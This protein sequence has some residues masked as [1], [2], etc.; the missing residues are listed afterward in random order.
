MGIFDFFS[1]GAI[2]Q[3]KFVQIVLAELRKLDAASQYHYNAERFQIARPDDGFINLGNIYQEYCQAEKIERD[4]VLRRFLRNCIS[5][6]N[7]E[8]PAEFGDIHPDLLPVIR[9]RF[10][11][12]SVLLQA[13]VRGNDAL[14]VPQQIVGEHLALS[15]VYD[16]PSAMR[17]ISLADLNNWEVSFDEAVEAARHNLE[18]MGEVAFATLDRCVY[19]SATGDNYDASRLVM[20]DLVRRFKVNGDYV[21]MVPNRDT[22]VITGSEDEHGL[23]ILAKLAEDSYEKPRPISTVAMRLEGEE[24]MPWLP[25]R[26]SPS[27]AK[28]HELRLRTIGAEYNDQKE[29]LDEVHS[30]SRADVSVA[31]FNAMQNKASGQ[32]TSYSVWSE[33]LDIMLP[34]TDSIFFFRPK[35]EKEGEIVAGGSWDHV[36][37]IVGNLM[38][39]AGIYPERYLVRDFPSDYQLDAI[40][41]QIEP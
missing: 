29:L 41:K 20:L 5:T 36:Q 40:G 15:L 22:L 7:Y 24:W 38:E 11:L 21:A 6:K 8:L 12:E 32:V 26:S 30:A 17:T 35:G 16:L 23:A 34:Q 39:P 1:G 37:Q 28:Y 2:T 19:A 10:Y 9:S 33:G 3:E 4:A 13:K 27:F 31:Q 18:Q 25:P 14:E